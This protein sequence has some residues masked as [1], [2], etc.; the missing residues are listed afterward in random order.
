[1][2][3]KT[4]KIIGKL[5]V[6]NLG[7]MYKSPNAKSISS[8]LNYIKKFSKKFEKDYE[9]KISK[10]RPK[11]LFEAIVKLEKIDEKMSK[12]I[13]YASLLHAENIENENYSH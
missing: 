7:D 12:I 8:D 10:L 5:P 6:W 2:T 4:D 3:T 11:Q 13:S 9:G 1:M